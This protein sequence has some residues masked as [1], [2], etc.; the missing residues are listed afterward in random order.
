MLLSHRA[1]R[2]AAALLAAIAAVS[3]TGCGGDDEADATSGDSTT[4]RLGYFPNLTHATAIVGVEDGHFAKALGANTL[5]TQ[6][7]NAGPEAT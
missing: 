3:L 1:G 4:L 5:K 7:F 2:L 6:T